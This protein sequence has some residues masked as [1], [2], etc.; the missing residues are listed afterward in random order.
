[1]RLADQVASGCLLYRPHQCWFYRRTPACPYFY[2]GTGIKLGSS[3]LPTAHHQLSNLP[4]ILCQRFNLSTSTFM[5]TLPDKQ[6]LNGFCF[7]TQ[8]KFF[9]IN[10]GCIRFHPLSYYFLWPFF[11]SP[12]P[13][14]LLYIFVVVVFNRDCVFL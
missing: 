10:Q 14:F 3:F 6:P 1:M 5:K 4:S 2:M 7:L 12:H 8:P 11:I 9:L 13:F